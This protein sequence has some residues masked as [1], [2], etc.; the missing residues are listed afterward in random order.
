MGRVVGEVEIAPSGAVVSARIL[1]SIPLLDTATLDAI[2]KWRY[3]PQ[4]REANARATVTVN[5]DLEY[6]DGTQPRR[7]HCTPTEAPIRQYERQLRR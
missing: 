3:R 6:A 7:E 5:F 2:R 4:R 1:C